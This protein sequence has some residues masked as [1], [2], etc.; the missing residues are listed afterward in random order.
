MEL[1]LKKLKKNLVIF[2]D[3]PCLNRHYFIT[4]GWAANKLLMAFSS[5]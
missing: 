1:I 5:A 3:Y 2:Y 4:V